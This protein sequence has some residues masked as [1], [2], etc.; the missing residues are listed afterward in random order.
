MEAHYCV[1]Y[2]V[3]EFIIES[4]LSFPEKVYKTLN[5]IG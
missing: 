3:D 4:F 1:L 5:I 2:N